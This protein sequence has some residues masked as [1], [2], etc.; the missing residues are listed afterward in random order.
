MIAHKKLHPGKILKSICIDDTGLSVVQ[1]ASALDV[2]RSTLSR[3]L[4]GKIAI[5][6][7]MSKRLSL[8]LGNPAEYWLR[9]QSDYDIW[10]IE[11][12]KVKY[13]VTPLQRLIDKA[14]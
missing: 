5:S 2:S 4:H 6:Q 13:N 12:S 3:L 9:L 8:F 10:V 11:K 7:E 1:V 14:A